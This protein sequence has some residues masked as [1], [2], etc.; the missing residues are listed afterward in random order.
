MEKCWSLPYLASL[1][2]SSGFSCAGNVMVLF[3][4]PFLS[5]ITRAPTIW[6]PA[7]TSNTIGRKSQKCPVK[8]TNRSGK[9]R[10]A[11]QKIIL[12][13]KKR[14]YIMDARTRN[15]AQLTM[16]FS[17]NSMEWSLMSN[18]ILKKQD[19]FLHPEK[20][21]EKWASC[22]FHKKKSRLRVTLE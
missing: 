2:L 3:L 6:E 13:W 20:E 17:A 8:H 14:T 5:S 19:I 11:W 1:V 18:D 10:W 9:G 16:W 22:W 7:T 21:S 15:S 4:K 12:N